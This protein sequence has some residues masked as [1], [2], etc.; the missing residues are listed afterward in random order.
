VSDLRATLLGDPADLA[1]AGTESAAQPGGTLTI[2][3]VRGRPAA[4]PGALAWD[5]ATATIAGEDGV[6]R[7]PRLS[8]AR[9]S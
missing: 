4:T 9:P 7:R 3:L 5:A 1:L 6:W 2:E 8:P